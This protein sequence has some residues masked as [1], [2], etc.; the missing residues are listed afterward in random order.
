M[1]HGVVAAVMLTEFMDLCMTV[2]AGRD[3]VIGTGGLDLIV[4]D[5]SIDQTLV[6]E[7]GLEKS[8][9]AA[10]AEVVGFIG[11]HVY[12]VLFPHHRLHNK[13]QIIGNGIAIAFPDN[14]AG[15]LNGELDFEIL[16]PVGIDLETALPDPF[17][18][19]LINVLYFKLVG[20]VEFFQS[21]PD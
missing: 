18:I 9:A 19:I 1:H 7:S 8:P 16:V 3:A 14:L 13:P 10:A 17:G 15:I 4:F 12:K 5:F 6:L 11:G 21:G 20:N 2:V